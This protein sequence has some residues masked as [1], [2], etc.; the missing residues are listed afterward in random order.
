M[1]LCC[2]PGKGFGDF[3]SVSDRD[4]PAAMGCR[5]PVVPPP[6]GRVGGLSPGES[7]WQSRGNRGWKRS[8]EVELDREIRILAPRRLPTAGVEVEVFK[9]DFVEGALE[10]GR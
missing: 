3:R 2:S 7:R 6:W 5:R 1:G 8:R 10:L 9:G 4:Y